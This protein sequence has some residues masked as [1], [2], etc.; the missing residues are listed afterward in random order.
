MCIRDRPHTHSAYLELLRTENGRQY[1]L[2]LYDNDSS[3]SSLHRATRIKIES[4]T[5]AEGDGTGHC[6]GI[7]TQ[8]FGGSDTNTGSKKNLIFRIT[9]HGQQGSSSDR[10]INNDDSHDDANQ[11]SCSYNRNLS[12][13]HGGEGWQTGDTVTVTLDQAQTSYDYTVR[14]EDHETTNVKASITTLRP[15]PTPFDADTAVTVDTI[16]GGIIGEL[17]GGI[18]YRVIGNGLYLYRSSA[19]NVEVVDQDLMRVCLLYTSPS[20]RDRG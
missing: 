11:Y 3:L 12:L 2:N 4:D 19:F 5:L 15:A 10:H 1:G 6:P 13:L 20:P 7:G 18:N 9:T 17:P 14:V 8:V 16:L